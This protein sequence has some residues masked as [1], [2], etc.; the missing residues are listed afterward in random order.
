MKK[1]QWQQYLVFAVFALT[2]AACGVLVGDYMRQA[3][4]SGVGLW[5][6]ILTIGL[7]FVGIYLSIFLQT[8]IHEGGHLIFGLCTGY[9]FSSFRIGSLMLTRREGKIVL[10]RMTVAGTGG[11]CLMSPPDLVDGKMPYVL[12]NL[13]GSIMNLLACALFSALFL[14]VSPQSVWAQQLLILILVG[15]ALALMNGIPLNLGNIDNDGRNAL[16][17]GRDPR[18]L[19]AF[20]IQMKAN[21]IT[22]AGVR[23]KDMPPEWFEDPDEDSLNNSMCAAIAVFSCSR[24]MDEHRFAEAEERIHRLL[25]MQTAVAG[26]HRQLLTCDLMYCEMISHNRPEV[27]NAMRTR[28]QRKFMRSMAAYPTVMR[29][30]YAWA[31]LAERDEQA[32]AKIRR[33]FEQRRKS[34]PYP[35]D[36]QSEWELME[37]AHRRASGKMEME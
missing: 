30:E 21:E 25:G 20:W 12:Y 31:L 34:Y 9:K 29:T 2:G 10:R 26:L 24:L 37:I 33:R 16:S 27:L 4:A 8:I 36:M 22:A 18:A 5:G 7:L 23:L 17:L 15:G 35:A 1:V 32:A 13:G 28:Q 11:Q 19:R 14:V 3:V 6:E